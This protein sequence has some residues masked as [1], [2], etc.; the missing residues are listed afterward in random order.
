MWSR[1]FF[2]SIPR[3]RCPRYFRP[4]W[5]Y[6]PRDALVIEP[7]NFCACD[8]SHPLSI[9]RRFDLAMSLEV[10]EHL[11]EASAD[12]FVSQLVAHAPVVLFSA[13]IPG[14]GGT[15]H[16]NEQWPSYWIKKFRNHGY[17]AFDFLR[18]LLWNDE[19]IAWWYRQN[20]MI[21]AGDEAHEANPLFAQVASSAPEPLDLVHPDLYSLRT[22]STG[23]V[24]KQLSDLLK[25]LA[26]G[27][28]FSVSRKTD[29]T[30]KID[31]AR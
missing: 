22:H 30:L 2:K 12:H 11:P 10:A 4:G 29:G 6:V 13:A 9:G 5:D 21:F 17:R 28:L 18:P 16:I 24:E 31:K 15:G 27:G 14:Q 1:A 25:Y 3:T 26:A 19:E 7:V 23:L 20:C 8:L